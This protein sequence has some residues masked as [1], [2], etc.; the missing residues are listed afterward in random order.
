MGLL[1]LLGC[2]TFSC[3]NS[4]G[5]SKC[6][7]KANIPTTPLVC[8]DN[9]PLF[10]MANRIGNGQVEVCFPGLGDV[11]PAFWMPDPKS[12]QIFQ[13]ADLILLNG[14][15][16][17]HWTQRVKLPR[18]RT[19]NTL[20]DIEQR[21]EIPAVFPS[22]KLNYNLWLNPVHATVQAKNVY[23]SLT[24]LKPESKTL[25]EKQLEGLEKDLN[26]MEEVMRQNLKARKGEVLLTNTYEFDYLF[27]QYGLEV[28]HFNWNV[29][30]SRREGEWMR[31][32]AYYQKY[33]WRKIICSELPPDP[34]REKLRQYGVEPMVLNSCANVCVEGDYLLVMKENLNKLDHLLRE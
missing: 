22:Q 23:S 29:N 28:M 26:E 17:S 18:K 13:S 19:V 15:G 5:K 30:A 32:K 21:I 24:R 9:Y 20:A 31:F 2:L 12:I 34:I 16:Y 25:F 6:H 27:E 33:H 4:E 8:V 11:N 10:Y 7:E 14:K 1:C 3:Q